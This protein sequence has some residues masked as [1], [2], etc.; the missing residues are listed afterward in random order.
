VS[1]EPHL[2]AGFEFCR[3]T[4]CHVLVP[5]RTS[6]WLY[7]RRWTISAQSLAPYRRKRC[8]ERSDL[9]IVDSSDVFN[10]QV[11]VKPKL[12]LRIQRFQ[13][14]LQKVHLLAV[15][16]WGELGVGARY[17]DQSHLIRDF[18]AF[19]PVSALLTTC[20]VCIIFV[21]WNGPI[22]FNHLRGWL[23]SLFSN[24]IPAPLF[25]LDS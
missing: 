23:T 12:F 15:V 21:T 2:R 8:E 16:D 14:V 1:A 4:F 22:K 11:G 6:P 19:S 10:F 9:A 7:C 17:F 25:T 3:M 18:V 20:D 5:D 13:R 24:T